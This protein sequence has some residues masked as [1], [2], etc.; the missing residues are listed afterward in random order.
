MD[1]REM[2]KKLKVFVWEWINQEDWRKRDMG[3]DFFKDN[4]FDWNK[5]SPAHWERYR[6][7]IVE[8]AKE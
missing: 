4:D 6:Q 1:K 3:F 7:L 8:F 2:R 5:I